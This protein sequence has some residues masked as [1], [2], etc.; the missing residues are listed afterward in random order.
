MVVAVADTVA[1]LT[2][3]AVAEANNTLKCEMSWYRPTLVWGYEARFLAKCTVV[4][5]VSVSVVYLSLWLRGKNEQDKVNV[6]DLSNM[7]PPQNS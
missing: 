6:E 7:V 3:V 2:V 1:A 5:V 4:V